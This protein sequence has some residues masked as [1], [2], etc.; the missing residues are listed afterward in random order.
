MR[1]ERERGAH[2]HTH[3]NI[4]HIQSLMAL[5]VKQEWK[6]VTCTR[7]T[8]PPRVTQFRCTQFQNYTIFYKVKKLEKKNNILETWAKFFTCGNENAVR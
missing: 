6:G 5:C 2:T 3:R 4:S 8:D 1:V 7:N